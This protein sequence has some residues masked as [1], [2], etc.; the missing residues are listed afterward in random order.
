MFAW[1]TKRKVARAAATFD[2]ITLSRVYGQRAL[3]EAQRLAARARH[4]GRDHHS[5]HWRLVAK[6]IG[7]G[8][9]PPSRDPLTNTPEILGA[10][11]ER[12]PRYQSRL[13][14]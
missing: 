3:A 1:M 10:A 12:W 9:M 5:R 2:A 7:R 14:A 4:D 13:A 11:G 8:R 6:E